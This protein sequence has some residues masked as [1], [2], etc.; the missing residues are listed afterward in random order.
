LF[1]FLFLTTLSVASTSPAGSF[2][3]G[4]VA[5]ADFLTQ[6]GRGNEVKADGF[7]DKTPLAPRVQEKPVVGPAPVS[8]NTIN[9]LTEKAIILHIVRAK[10]SVG[11]K[12]E[13]GGVEKSVLGA[14]PTLMAAI[15]S[16]N[17]AA[18]NAQQ[19]TS[20]VNGTL[21]MEF[22]KCTTTRDYKISLQ[23]RMEIVCGSGAEARKIYASV[24]VSPEGGFEMTAVPYVMESARGTFTALEQNSK[25]FHA[26]SGS[27]N[28][29]TFVDTKALERVKKEMAKT[30]ADSSSSAAKEYLAKKNE[31]SSTV[32]QT[33]TSTVTATTAPEP[34][35]SDY[36][37]GVL[38]EVLAKGISAGAEQLYQDLGYVYFVPQGTPVDVEIYYKA[39]P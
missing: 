28:L 2:N 23:N 37:I 17:Q 13:G 39:Q 30:L 5:G 36:G 3:R 1:S 29:A 33:E 7:A 14:P 31:S 4:D 6:V 18:I 9:P 16:H 25:L 15:E 26:I 38:V 21:Q 8:I 24:A 10:Q 27:T 12:G 22:L 11:K 34:K 20:G 32:S 35:A 19:A